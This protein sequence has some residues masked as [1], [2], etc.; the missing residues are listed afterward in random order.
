[1]HARHLPSFEFQ[2]ERWRNG[3]GWTRA[4]LSAPAAGDAFAWRAS[5][6]EI[7][8]DCRFSAFPGYE[9]QLILL[10]GEGARLA[11]DDGR[12]CVLEP[13]HGRAAFAGEEAP[14]CSVEGRV[15]VF[16]LIADRG[17]VAIEL[18]HRPLVGPMVFFPEAGVQWLLLLISG[19][20]GLPDAPNRLALE[21]G[22]ALLLSPEAESPRRLVLSGG[23]EILLARIA[24][25]DR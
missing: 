17:A 8:Q 21:Q 13:P 19:R 12:E 6:A 20:A 22:D 25:R 16:N 4:I 9:R 14:Q 15:Q 1:M 3:A 24:T 7:D 11:F 18:L 23:G 10:S 5:I 2:R